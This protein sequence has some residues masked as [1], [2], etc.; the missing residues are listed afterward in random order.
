[1]VPMQAQL[2]VVKDKT[3]MPHQAPTI[4]PEPSKST[5]ELQG[6]KWVRIDRLAQDSFNKSSSVEVPCERPKLEAS[7]T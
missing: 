4:R 3:V 7:E 1:V 5:P 6:R 2:D